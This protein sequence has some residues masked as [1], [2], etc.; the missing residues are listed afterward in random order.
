M[1][2]YWLFFTATSGAGWMDDW[3]RSCSN[4][5][6]FGS[7]S[8][9]Q[10]L[11][12]FFS[13]Y[14]MFVEKAPVRGAPECVCSGWDFCYPSQAI[15]CSGPGSCW[16]KP[17]YTMSSVSMIFKSI[18]SP[19]TASSTLLWRPPECSKF[20]C[21]AERVQPVLWTNLGWNSCPALTLLTQH[22]ECARAHPD[23]RATNQQ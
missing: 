22:V 14:T 21:Q 8:K 15:L 10:P 23:G 2:Y 4:W 12:V 17:R 20:W 11:R 5:C 1:N 6:Y 16:G 13:L 3:L 9:C 19:V 7:L 18:F